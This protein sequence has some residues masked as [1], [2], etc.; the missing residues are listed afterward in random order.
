M[1]VDVETLVNNA[2]IVDS[3]KLIFNNIFR[4][5]PVHNVQ[6]LSFVLIIKFI[7]KK[8]LQISPSVSRTLFEILGVYKTINN[9]I[10]KLILINQYRSF[11]VI[12]SNIYI[13]S[14]NWN[15]YLDIF[16]F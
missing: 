5:T 14:Y 13:I 16:F 8:F 9:K 2:A 3:I 15:Y 10:L 11:I 12:I 1:S 6:S 4:S 7:H